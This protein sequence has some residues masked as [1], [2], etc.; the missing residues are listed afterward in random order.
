VLDRLLAGSVGPFGRT[1][2]SIGKVDLRRANIAS[3]V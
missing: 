2:R 3:E 1:V